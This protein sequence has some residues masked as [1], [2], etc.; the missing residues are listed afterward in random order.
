MSSLFIFLLL[1]LFWSIGLYYQFNRISRT[2]GFTT[3]TSI[4]FRVIFNQYSLLENGS[5]WQFLRM[6]LLIKVGQLFL[7]ALLLKLFL[8]PN[9]CEVIYL[10]LFLVVT[11][12]VLYYLASAEKGRSKEFWSIY[13]LPG[14]YGVYELTIS[15]SSLV[16]EWIGATLAEL[17]LRKKELLVLSILRSGKLTIFPKGP[18]IL[19][20]G[21]RLLIFGKSSRLPSE[22]RIETKKNE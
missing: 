4:V 10:I 5:K 20:A 13:S 14:E 11:G 9:L 6:A 22:E 7:I 19:L 16:R 3:A 15:E 18:E 12:V 21:D 17:D 1:F 2:S 8:F